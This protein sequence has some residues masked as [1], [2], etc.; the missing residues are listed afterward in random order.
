MSHAFFL[1]FFGLVAIVA[2]ALLVSETLEVCGT[3]MTA[4]GFLIFLLELRRRF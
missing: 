1:V 3:I 2:G 4:L